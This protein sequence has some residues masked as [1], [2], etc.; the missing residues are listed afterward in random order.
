M[1][2]SKQTRTA[3]RHPATTLTPVVLHLEKTRQLNSPT[4]A[5]AESR[6]IT[7]SAFGSHE[8]NHIFMITSC[9]KRNV[10]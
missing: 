8:L 7:V 6:E 9:S 5:M 3:R 10:S 4:H 2:T 1:L